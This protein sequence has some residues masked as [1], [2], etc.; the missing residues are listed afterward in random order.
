[1]T[2]AY[3]HPTYS[4]VHIKFRA[5]NAH[6]NIVHLIDSNKIVSSCANKITVTSLKIY[7]R[8]FFSPACSLARSDAVRNVIQMTKLKS[9]FNPKQ[10]KCKC[11]SSKRATAMDITPMT[12]TRCVSVSLDLYFTS[13]LFLFSSSTLFLSFLYFHQSFSL[14]SSALILPSLSFLLSMCIGEK[15]EINDVMRRKSP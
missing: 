8:C 14:F 10:L 4:Q 6:S 1:M 5:V 12:W 11:L 13:L 3:N 9:N 2:F 7:C 15:T